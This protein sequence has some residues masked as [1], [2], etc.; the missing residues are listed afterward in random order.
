MATAAQRVLAIPE[1]L[2]L[3]LSNVPTPPPVSTTTGLPAPEADD[4]RSAEL[5]T[6]AASLR[7][8]L[9]VQRVCSQWRETI[10]ASTPLQ[11]ALFLAAADEGEIGE[12]PRSWDATR[13]SRPVLNPVVQAGW[14]R[15]HC[16]FLT[17]IPLEQMSN[18]YSAYMVLSRGDV[19]AFRASAARRPRCVE[20][21]VLSQPP[22]KEVA[23][24]VWERY[25]PRERNSGEDDA[26]DD[27]DDDANQGRRQR[28]SM[29]FYSVKK[30]KADETRKLTVGLLLERV[31][32]MF[33]RDKTLKAIKVCTV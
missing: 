9:R 18:R 29:A 11:K 14:Q 33:G 5:A 21:M 4:P 17:H 23:A 2:E 16:R 6:Y 3:I 12:P 22:C 32:E 24:I 7:S 1:L 19:E 10:K 15:W 13:G 25:D 28:M 20:G 27:D 30:I 31:G 26:E 8:L